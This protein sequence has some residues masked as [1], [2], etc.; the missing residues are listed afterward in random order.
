MEFT[1]ASPINGINNKT[2]KLSI[3]S[4]NSDIIRTDIATFKYNAL[5]KNLNI[6]QLGDILRDNGFFIQ[7][8]HRESSSSKYPDANDYDVIYNGKTTN[9]TTTSN[10]L[11][12]DPSDIIDNV[13]V[14]IIWKSIANYDSRFINLYISWN[15]FYWKI[16][17]VVASNVL[18]GE[19]IENTLIDLGLPM[20]D[21]FGNVTSGIDIDNTGFSLRILGEINIPHN[22]TKIIK[23]KG[24]LKG[25]SKP[26]IFTYKITFK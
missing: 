19:I 6:K 10:T 26:I 2:I 1:K 13:E 8:N 16:Q 15:A 17:N 21:L 25:Y 20:V 12:Q 22:T 5:T 9:F 14:D 11:L 7:F 24:G 3:S 18:N 23:V 4:N